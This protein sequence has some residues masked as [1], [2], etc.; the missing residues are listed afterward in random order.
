MVK[1]HLDTGVGRKIDRWRLGSSSWLGERRKVVGKKEGLEQ[2]VVAV[3]LK[4][5]EHVSSV[6]T[7]LVEFA[8]GQGGADMRMG[9]KGG[10]ESTWARPSM[11]GLDLASSGCRR[12][13]GEGGGSV[14]EAGAPTWRESRSSRGRLRVSSGRSPLPSF[15]NRG[16][17]M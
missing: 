10:T 1:M 2:R 7:M 16:G 12:P 15:G 4:D 14:V 8:P 6:T 11:E 3:V 17:V 13:E 9:V 5:M